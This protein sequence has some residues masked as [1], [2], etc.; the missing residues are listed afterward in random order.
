[1]AP[2]AQE[3]QHQVEGLSPFARWQDLLAPDRQD[4]WTILTFTGVVGLLG[5]A[6]PITVE[7]LVNT[8]AFGTLLQPVIVLALVLFTFLVFMAAIASVQR[9]VAEIIHRRLFVRVL[10]GCA[11]R[12]P[13]ASYDT[14]NGRN[15]ELVNRFLEIVTVDK[16]GVQL[17][18]DATFLLTQTI[19][20]MV[21]LAFYHPYLLGFDLVLVATMTFV[22][23]VLGRHSVTTSI[24]ESR[25]KYRS[26]AWLEAMAQSPLA[27]KLADVDQFG[28]E[29]TTKLAADYL[30]ARKAHFSILMRQIIFALFLQAVASTALL[31]IGGWLVINGGLTL[32]QLVAAEL[33]VSIIVGGFAKAG[34]HFEGFYDLMAAVDK[35]RHLT[36]MPLEDDSGKALVRQDGAAALRLHTVTLIR[37]GAT[38]LDQLDL[39]IAAGQRVALVG[40]AGSGKSSLLEML[41]GLHRPNSGYWTLDDLD[42]RSL[43]LSSLRNAVALVGDSQLVPGSIADNIRLGRNKIDEAMVREAF[44]QTG[45]IDAIS[46][47]PDGADTRLDVGSTVLSAAQQQALM[48]ARAIVTRPRLLLIDEAL[49]RLD[50]RLRSACADAVL[51]AAADWTILIV[52]QRTDII[53]RCQATLTLPQGVVSPPVRGLLLTATQNPIAGDD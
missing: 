37:H 27:F 26:L 20:S 2:G 24:E 1:M 22:V 28:I 18:L 9:Y 42:C 50:Y 23:L 13:R 15:T 41:F 10:I 49:D 46:K 8:V 14:L 43:R 47:L 17:L 40:A 44:E 21:V 11:Q 16:V 30:V 39:D 51:G 36:E 3:H 53:E 7:S 45:L 4:I 19:V 29:T 12:I 48:V 33:L 34:K 38:I 25:G 35:L 5:L 52:T 31:G 32:G 6:T